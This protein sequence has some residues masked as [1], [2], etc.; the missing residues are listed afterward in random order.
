MNQQLG[1]KNTGIKYMISI[2]TTIINNQNAIY[3]RLQDLH[4]EHVNIFK[5]LSYNNLNTSM[6]P[7][8]GVN[9]KTIYLAF[10]DGWSL[11]D[12]SSLIGEDVDKVKARIDK[13]MKEST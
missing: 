5:K 13:Y 12:L 1:N 11:S 8:K 2:L 9:N 7:L 6:K 10:K 3:H 4:N